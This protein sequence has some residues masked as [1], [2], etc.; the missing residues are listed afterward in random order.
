VQDEK[1][2]LDPGI[3]FGKSVEQNLELLNRLD[4]IRALGFPVLLG[5]SPQIV[6]RLHTQ[7]APRAACRRHAAAVAVGI[8]RGADIIRVH[9]VEMM[10]RVA[11]MTMPSCGPKLN[12]RPGLFLMHC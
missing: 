4:E 6:H 10:A 11:R 1:I 3:G 7:P 5:P 8:A 9:D 2:I 12:P